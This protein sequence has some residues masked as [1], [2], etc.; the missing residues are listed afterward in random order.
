MDQLLIYCLSLTSILFTDAKTP[1]KRK[2]DQTN[3]TKETP[4]KPHDTSKKES[5]LKK[6]SP[7]KKDSPSKPTPSKNIANARLS[8]LRAQLNAE[9]QSKDDAE[10][11]PVKNK[12]VSPK[13]P[14]TE[15][16]LSKLELKSPNFN[17]SK[18][19]TTQSPSSD[20][21]QS[22][23]S[24]S[25][26]FAANK[27]I[28]SMKAQLPEE[29]SNKAKPKDTFA[30]IEEGICNQTAEY[31]FMKHPATPPQ[32]SE[33]SKLVSAI[34][35]KLSYKGYTKDNLRTFST[36][37]DRMEALRTRLSSEAMDTKEIVDEDFLNSIELPKYPNEAME[38]EECKEVGIL[39]FTII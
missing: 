35:S 8:Q 27:I 21:I 2:F 30:D 32:F 19:S 16:K 34:K 36:A 5:P 7:I 17:E 18:C 39:L 33:A 31:P 4:V 12:K 1:E 26:F 11:S 20:S 37:K 3:Y 10:K 22:I 29:Y 6:L 15:T 24:P 23:P 13:T 28:Y 14:Q 25:Q 38:I 9:T